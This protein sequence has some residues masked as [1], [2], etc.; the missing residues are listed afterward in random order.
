MKPGSSGSGS[1]ARG[2]VRDPV[3]GMDVPAD[4]TLAF[5]HG[6]ITWRFCNPKCLSRFRDDPA[7]FLRAD[8]D[9]AAMETPAPP[10]PGV[11]YICPMDPDVESDR[12]GS[13]PKCGMALE[14][15]DAGTTRSATMMRDTSGNWRKC[16]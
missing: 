14:R 11:G 3:C 15:A 16:P 6:Q 7:K 1:G 8:P 4:A 10:A 12:P 5:D 2:T 13:C 9:A